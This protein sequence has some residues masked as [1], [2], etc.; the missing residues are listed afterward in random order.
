MSVVVYA[1]RFENGEI[2]VGMTDD[3]DRRMTE[4]RRRQSPSTRRFRGGFEIIYQA[5]FPDYRQARAHEKFLK[6]G[7]GRSLLARRQDVERP[8]RCQGSPR[9]TR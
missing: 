2:Y 8:E 4:H 3:L 6:S 5:T 7:A 9:S 1:I